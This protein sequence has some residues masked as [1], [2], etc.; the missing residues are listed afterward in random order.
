MSSKFCSL[1]GQ[2][3]VFNLYLNTVAS[4]CRAYPEPWTTDQ[5]VR[6]KII[7]WNHEAQLL[8]QG[9]EIS[10]CQVCWNDEKQNKL[11][12]RLL[13][14]QVDKSF[15]QIDIFLSNLCNQ[16]C[17]YCS[18]NYSSVWEESIKK[19][20]KFEQVSST[21]IKNLQIS[22][23]TQSSH[24]QLEQIQSYIQS[25]DDNSVLLKLLGGEPLMQIHSLQQLLEFSQT[26]IKNLQIATNLNPPSSKFLEW[27]LTNLPKEKLTFSISLDA[28]P[29][30]NHLPRAGFDATKFLKNLEL[31]THH[32]IKINFSSVVSATSIFD[33]PNFLNWIKDHGYSAGF[34]SLNNPNCLN[35]EVVPLEFRQEILKNIKIKMPP[36][37]NEI[38]NYGQPTV[39][40]KLFEQYNYLT[41]YFDRTN[42]DLTKINNPLFQEYWQ[43]LTK[44]FK[45]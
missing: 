8:D 6:E 27:V 24:N 22:T 14:G 25:R 2:Q 29:E 45:K 43:W 5:T 13:E 16:M 32:Q 41:Q 23:E 44:K 31:L 7:Q 42:T 1:K 4:C 35:P 36:L 38:L 18:P 3:Q 40:L 33:L 15:N 10:G 26:K 20:G 37:I 9:I 30:F 34:Y 28:T 12:Y 19:L 11:S 39:D 17:S 21:A